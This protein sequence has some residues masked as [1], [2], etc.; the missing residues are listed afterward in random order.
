MSEQ[1]LAELIA[2]G[3]EQHGV[4]FKPP[5]LRADA[6]LFAVVTRAVLGMANRRDGGLVVVGVEELPANGGLRATGLNPD[7]LASWNHDDVTA[8]LNAAADPF[9]AVDVREVRLGNPG[10]TLV[11]LHVQEF[12][13]I[14]VICRRDYNDRSA[15][16]LLRSGAIY[17]RT[18]RKPETSEIPSQTE[19]REL[20]EIAI[21]KGVRKF[22]QHTR[23][24][25]LN[26]MA[27][28][29]PTDDEAFD[30]QLGDFR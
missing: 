26:L 16:P 9:V 29:A 7:Q 12:E 13:D 21:Q 14:P 1:E 24:A 4:E 11:V 27:P 23:A 28:H 22:V 15:R 19:M 30:R 18:R 6:Y 5:G 8:G 3:H 20:V 17:V 2:G 10:V 25:G